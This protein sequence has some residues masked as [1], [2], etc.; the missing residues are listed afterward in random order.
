M[1]LCD[2]VC[3]VCGDRSAGKHYGVMACYGKWERSE[4]LV[5]ILIDFHHYK[6]HQKLLDASNWPHKQLF[7]HKW[8]EIHGV[9]YRRPGA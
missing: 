4:L 3:M 2:G 1:E 6:L 9:Y 7:Y 5:P 8:N